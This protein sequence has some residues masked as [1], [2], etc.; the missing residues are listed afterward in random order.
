MNIYLKQNL[1]NYIHHAYNAL[2]YKNNTSKKIQKIILLK[3]KRLSLEKV[4]TD[5]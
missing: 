5:A 2:L 1:S 3:I 4:F